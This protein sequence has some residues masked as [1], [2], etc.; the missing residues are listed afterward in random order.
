M[1]RDIVR[2]MTLPVLLLLSTWIVQAALV[3]PPVVKK[4]LEH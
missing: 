4:I 2:W 3:A 1:K